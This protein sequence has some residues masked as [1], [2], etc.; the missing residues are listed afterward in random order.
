[1]IELIVKNWLSE[2]LPAPAYA[3]LPSPIPPACVVVEKTGGG[4]EGPGIRTAMLAVQSYGPSRLEAMR[5]NENVIHTMLRMVELDAVSSIDLNSDYP[6][7]D[8]SNK[9][10]RYQA[11]FDV[12]YFDNE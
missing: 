9:R 8:Q 4:R 1:M 11:V 6:F 5:L 3:E 2:H 7:F 10:H 12:V